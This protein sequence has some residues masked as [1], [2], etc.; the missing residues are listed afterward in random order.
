MAEYDGRRQ[1]RNEIKEQDQSDAAFRVHPA[2]FLGHDFRE[3]AQV[4]LLHL[5]FKAG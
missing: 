4:S 2:P 5:T 1:L 3:H